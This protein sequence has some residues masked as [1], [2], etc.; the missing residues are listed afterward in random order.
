MKPVGL[1]LINDMYF[2]K[3]NIKSIEDDFGTQTEEA[4][5]AK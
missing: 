3:G 4:Y 5:C 1:D 2:F